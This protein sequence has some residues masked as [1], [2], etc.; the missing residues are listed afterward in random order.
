MSAPKDIAAIVADAMKKKP[1]P[2]TVDELD[3]A[4]RRQIERMAAQDNTS[5]QSILDAARAVQDEKIRQAE[6][7][8]DFNAALIAQAARNR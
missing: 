8:G 5:P 7:S 2:A 4:T 1:L 3:P 6:G